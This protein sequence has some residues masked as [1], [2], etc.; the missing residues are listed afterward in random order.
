DVLAGRTIPWVKLTH[1][2]AQAVH[3]GRQVATYRVVSGGAPPDLSG[4]SHFFWTSGSHFLAAIEHQPEILGGWHACGPGNS[5]TIIRERLGRDDRL[6]VWLSQ[7]EWEKNV[8]RPR[9]TAGFL[10]QDSAA[11]TI[12]SGAM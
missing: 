2:R 6:E 3:G 11:I 1:D 10:S 4:Y 5:W 12:P 9:R 7:E 8:T